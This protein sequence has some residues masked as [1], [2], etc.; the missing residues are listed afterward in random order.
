VFV[1]D[2]T[3][4]AIDSTGTACEADRYRHPAKTTSATAT[5]DAPRQSILLF[6]TSS[7]YAPH[8]D[9][10]AAIGLRFRTEGSDRQNQG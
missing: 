9:F 1:A 10:D 7:P 8:R 5:T 6:F 2:E 3:V 4:D